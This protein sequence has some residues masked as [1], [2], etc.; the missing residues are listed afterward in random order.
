M[1]VTVA[2]LIKGQKPST[3]PAH[4][5]KGQAMGEIT[6]MPMLVCVRKGDLV[7]VKGSTARAEVL[8]T[9]GDK[10]MARFQGTTEVIQLNGVQFE[11]SYA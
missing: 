10:V 1:M 7:P 2:A 4:I 3:N 11:E 8:G 5:Q 6:E 9:Y